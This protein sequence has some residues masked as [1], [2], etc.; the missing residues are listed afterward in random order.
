MKRTLNI[1]IDLTIIISIVAFVAAILFNYKLSDVSLGMSIFFF[2][3]MKYD[4]DYKKFTAK[5]FSNEISEYRY[6]F[7]IEKVGIILL[8]LGVIFHMF[9][10]YSSIIELISGLCSGVSFFMITYVTWGIKFINFRKNYYK[11]IKRS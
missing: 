11:S 5:Y 7:I 2:F 6:F 4:K 8:L 10:D 3:S 1:L 9:K